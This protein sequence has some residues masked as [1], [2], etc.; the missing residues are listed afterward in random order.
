MIL[1][2]IALVVFVCMLIILLCDV[3]ADEFGFEIF[4]MI[5]QI[6]FIGLIVFLIIISIIF[7]YLAFEFI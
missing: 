1:V 3:L 4:E 6:V 7:I 5:R 2:I